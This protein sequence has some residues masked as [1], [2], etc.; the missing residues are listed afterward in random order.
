[1]ITSEVTCKTMIPY[2]IDSLP[3]CLYVYDI[4]ATFPTTHVH[5]ATTDLQRRLGLLKQV[6]IFTIT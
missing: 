1:M 3:C 5:Y 2:N 4:T 6:T